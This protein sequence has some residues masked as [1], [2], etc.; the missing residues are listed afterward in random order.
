[1]GRLTVGPVVGVLGALVLPFAAARAEEPAALSQQALSEQA[2]SEQAPSEQAPNEQAPNE[3]AATPTA[4]PAAPDREPS[5]ETPDVT[6][7]DVE[8]LPPEAITIHRG[9]YAHGFFV[10]AKFGARVFI[11]GAGDVAEP[12]PKL[13]LDF[14][15]E[16]FDWLHLLAGFEGSLHRTRAPAPPSPRVFEVVGSTV[17]GRLQGN[18][19]PEFAVWLSGQFGLLLVTTDVL[20]LYGYQDAAAVGITYGGEAGVDFHL[21]ARHHSL[22]VSGGFRHVPSFQPATGGAAAFDVHGQGY[23]RYVF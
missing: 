23:L 13:T 21:R 7:L 5:P 14:G 18:I 6:R 15:Y 22:G 11:N 19:S 12:G 16:L 3:G 10:E 20:G 2:L 8:R 17:A 1:M 9:L 4:G